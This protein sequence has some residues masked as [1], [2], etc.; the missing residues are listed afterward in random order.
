[1]LYQGKQIE[2]LAKRSVFGKQIAEVKRQN[3]VSAGLP[4]EVTLLEKIFGE[5]TSPQQLEDF[6]KEL[7][8]W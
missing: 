7:A 5:A 2:I 1:M 6:R 3:R 8:N 4:P